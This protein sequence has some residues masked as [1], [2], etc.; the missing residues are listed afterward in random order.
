MTDPETVSNIGQAG[1]QDEEPIPP[2]YWWLKRILATIG[3]LV[4]ALACLRWWWGWEAHRRL[5]AEI[6]RYQAAGQLV[7][8][9]EFDKEMDAVPDDQNTAVLL[10]RAMDGITASTAS[11]VY[12]TTFID[13]PGTFDTNMEAAT[14]LMESNRDVLDLV[15]LA[16]DRP[17]VAWS[18][19]L[20]GSIV[21]LNLNIG[22][23]SR[24][25]L[26]AKLLWFSATYHYRTGNHAEAVDT[27]HDFLRF[28]E[29]VDTHPMLISSLVSWACYS[30]GCSL[31]EEFGSDLELVG[32]QSEP[33]G[34][35]KP[36]HRQQVERLIVEM[37]DDRMP[38]EALVRTFYGERAY[39]LAILDS[40]YRRRMPFGRPLPKPTVWGRVSDFLKRPLLQLDVIRVARYD[41][42]LAE[43]AMSAT[44][45]D[46]SGR[47]P[48]RMH[49]PSVIREASR[50]LSEIE[51][52]SHNRS[53]ELFFRHLAQ[54]RMAATA[55]AIRL[56]EVDNGFRP[57]S[58]SE[59]V[60]EYLTHVP[61]DSFSPDGACIRYKPDA[62][63]AVLYSVGADGNDN[64][65]VVA[66]RPDGP[67]D[68]SRSDMLF[69]LDGRPED[70]EESGSTGSGQA[71]E[72]D[73]NV[74]DK[75]ADSKEDHAGQS[76]PQ[77][78]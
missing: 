63:E 57:R 19:R 61:A 72:D 41:T 17:Q 50:L 7:Y 43:A 53:I 56:F 25:R 76:G 26:L 64:G 65:G 32:A 78:R 5:Q 33:S 42:L 58:L 31:I 48:V 37:I 77:R 8:A 2:R 20:K 39:Y 10:E 3:V 54:R 45:A 28:S 35:V 62:E 4:L 9:Y 38:R 55:L 16:R 67:R 74:E 23:W 46:V 47:L 51:I 29:A 34:Q 22:F 75:E 40:A 27:M 60:P 6:E 14:E 69:Y 1:C 71:G 30:L 73:Q 24:Q 70:K 66:L 68:G 15:R 59:L 21:S 52:P 44:W 36:A 49:Q 13:G 12:F 18:Q 11:G